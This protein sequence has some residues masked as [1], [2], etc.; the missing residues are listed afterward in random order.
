M[1]D[2]API[3]L[4]QFKDQIIETAKAFQEYVPTDGIVINPYR[5]IAMEKLGDFREELEKHRFRLQK[6]D[7][8]T[9]ADVMTEI[10][11]PYDPQIQNG[12]LN[13]DNGNASV[14]LQTGVVIAAFLGNQRM[15]QVVELHSPAIAEYLHDVYDIYTVDPG[16]P[17]IR[18]L[19]RDFVAKHGDEAGNLMPLLD[20][21]TKTFVTE[22]HL[23]P[24]QEN[25]LARHMFLTGLVEYPGIGCEVEVIRSTQNGK[26]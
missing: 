21:L 8:L 25:Y 24:E 16:D 18:E 23:I 22:I 4:H 17:R 10:L 13:T 14:I 15:L 9:V 19:S 12:V 2:L 11:A 26:S 20:Q 7:M 1:R 6:V 3:L 5:K